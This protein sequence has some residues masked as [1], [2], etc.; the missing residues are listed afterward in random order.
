[1]T[2]LTQIPVTTADGSTADLSDHKG[3]VLLIV[4]VASKCGFTPQYEGLEA[5]QREL[6]RARAFR[7][8]ASPATSSAR[9]NRAMPRKSPTS[10]S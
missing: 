3:K 8:L 10:A 5:L 9:R 2:E 1:M 6:C 4:N 7:C